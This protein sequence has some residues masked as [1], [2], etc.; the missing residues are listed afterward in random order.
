[1]LSSL[2]IYKLSQGLCMVAIKNQPV[3][4]GRIIQLMRL[5]LCIGILG[6]LW[7]FW[8]RSPALVKLVVDGQK[9]LETL[10]QRFHAAGLPVTNLQLEPRKVQVICDYL[11]AHGIRE[12]FTD[13]SFRLEEHIQQRIVEGCW[14]IRCSRFLLFSGCL[15]WPFNFG[16]H[17]RRRRQGDLVLFFPPSGQRSPGSTALGTIMFLNFQW[18]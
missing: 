3:P 10:P 9:V 14:P 6:L 16:S 17:H 7:I 15:L 11:T 2:C 13:P 12:Y 18:H 4:L 8:A 5:D 1:M